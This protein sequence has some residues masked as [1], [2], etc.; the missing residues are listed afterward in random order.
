[1][2]V[3]RCGGGYGA[4]ISRNNLVS[5]ICAIAAHLSRSPVHLNVDLVTNMEMVGKR[6][7]CY[8]EYEVRMFL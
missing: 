7:P 3:K 4:K 1:M 2:S 8:T 5:A 6:F